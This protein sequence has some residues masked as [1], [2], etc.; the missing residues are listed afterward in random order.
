MKQNDRFPAECVSYE[1]RILVIGVKGQMVHLGLLYK[2]MGGIFKVSAL[3][4]R[5]PAA[6][7][8]AVK[9]GSQ[10]PSYETGNSLLRRNIASE[11]VNTRLS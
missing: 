6:T 4:H 5:P 7:Q 8:I 2:C 1:S 3:L 10:L 9:Q 11:G